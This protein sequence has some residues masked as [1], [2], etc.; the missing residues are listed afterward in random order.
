MGL[1]HKSGER[2]CAPALRGAVLKLSLFLPPLPCLF[3]IWNFWGH[4]DH[5]VA[6]RQGSV[7]SQTPS[8]LHTM[9]IHKWNSTAA[10]TQHYAL[11]R[12]PQ[13]LLG[14]TPPCNKQHHRPA[15]PSYT[16]SYGLI[17]MFDTIYAFALSSLSQ[18][19]L[20]YLAKLRVCWNNILFCSADCKK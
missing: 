8:V 3:W 5:F 15:F 19:P 12:S 17:C 2:N 4:S 1:E 11:Y 18:Q 13:D 20:H 16:G 7:R 6:P 14:S 10:F 9:G